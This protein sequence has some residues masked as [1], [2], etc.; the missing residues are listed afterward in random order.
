MTSH[1]RGNSDTALIERVYMTSE[2]VMSGIN[3]LNET[4]LEVEVRLLLFYCYLIKV[5]SMLKLVW[6]IL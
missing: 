5:F 6:G 2:R 3:K 4:Y 1:K